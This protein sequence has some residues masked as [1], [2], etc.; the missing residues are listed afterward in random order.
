MST[1]G[2]WQALTFRQHIQQVIWGA[3]KVPQS[4][5]TAFLAWESLAMAA[6]RS[7]QELGS[8][9]SRLCHNQ[10]PRTV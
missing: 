10:P 8:A 7:V 3:S 1:Y 2:F 9:A 6:C 4:T 5:S